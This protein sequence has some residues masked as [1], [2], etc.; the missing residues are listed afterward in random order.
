MRPAPCGLPPHPQL[1]RPLLHS[2]NVISPTT[3][4]PSTCGC[5]RAR[6]KSSACWVA[7]P[8]SA[9]S[10]AASCTQWP[11]S[12]PGPPS[13]ASR[14]RPIPNTPSSTRRTAVR[15]DHWRAG[16]LRH[17][18]PCAAHAAA[19]DAGARTARPV[20]RLA[21]RHGAA[22]QPGLDGLSVLLADEV[23]ARRADRLSRQRHHDPRRGHA[24][25]RHRHDLGCRRADLGGQP[26]R[27]S[28][29]RGLAPVAANAGHALRDPAS[30]GA[31]RRCATTSASRQP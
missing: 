26:D 29:R 6:W 7:A 14:A 20:P 8:S 22:R 13:A 1:P 18:Q 19:T 23:A 25:A 31:A 4:L 17:V 24:G 15:A 3:R 2:R 28:A 16:G 10:A 9:S 11:T 27:G 12:M 5:R 30:S 21:G